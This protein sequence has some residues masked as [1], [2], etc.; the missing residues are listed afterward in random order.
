VGWV[1]TETTWHAGLYW[2]HCTS[3]HDRWW[4]VWSSRWNENW[5]GKPKHSEKLCPSVT[6]STT[7]FTW[8][9]L[10]SNPVLCGGN[11]A[12][13]RLSLSP[14]RRYPYTEYSTGTSTLYHVA[15]HLA[16]WNFAVRA[17][18][19]TGVTFRVDGKVQ[20]PRVKDFFAWR[21]SDP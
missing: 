11:P 5:Q 3:P 16:G 6:S 14:K 15:W 12:T 7:N 18:W 2:A 19:L 9:D 8:P 4:W 13:N 10:A 21:H 17:I 1:E 20:R